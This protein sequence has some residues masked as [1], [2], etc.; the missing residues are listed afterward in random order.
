MS[1]TP[2]AAVTPPPG[3]LLQ[4]DAS[5]CL[6]CPFCN[7]IATHLDQVSA[8]YPSPSDY[9]E[10]SF[11]YRTATFSAVTGEVTHGPLTELKN[12]SRRHWL[13]IHVNCE[14]CPGGTIILAQNKGATMVSLVPVTAPTTAGEAVSRGW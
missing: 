9:D 1:T 3:P 7:D 12:S 11:D 10:G 8:G 6:V 13:E 4:V 14:T 2:T 5:G